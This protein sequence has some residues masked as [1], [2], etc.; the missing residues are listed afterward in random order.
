MPKLPSTTT[1]TAA[2]IAFSAALTNSLPV[3]ADLAAA[4]LPSSRSTQV[5]NMVTV[6]ST[7]I[8]TGSETATACRIE[9]QS[10]L[11][12]V[13]E[14]QTTDPATNLPTGVANT[15]VD[16]GPGQSQ[17]FVLSLTPTAIIDSVQVPFSFSCTS[18]A[19]AGTISGVNT[20]LLSASETP[21]VD[22]I[23]LAA[24]GG[25]TG[26]LSHD[27]SAGAFSLATVNVGA[28]DT[29][30]VTADTGAA[31]L[32]L[33]LSVCETNPD[34]GACVQGPAGS[35]D[36]TMST[37]ATPTFSV[38]SQASAAV[39]NNPAINRIFVRFTDSAAVV[40]GATSVALANELTNVPKFSQ[41]TLDVLRRVF[42]LTFSST[43]SSSS[44]SG[45]S[46]AGPALQV[47]TTIN[48]TVTCE[49]TGQLVV[50]GTSDVDQ[51]G[52]SSS[53]TI[54]FQNCDGINGEVNV[55][56]SVSLDGTTLSFETIQNGSYSAEECEEITMTDVQ[57]RGEVDLTDA[58]E[59]II[60]GNSFTTSGTISGRCEGET[61]SCSLDGVDLEDEDAFIDNCSG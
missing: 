11:P 21:V 46:A 12:I 1:A 29:V 48:E 7:V 45:I 24:T 55:T 5:D 3:S 52:G 51:N 30:T 17:S 27:D 37:G 14:Y 13:L 58:F 36:V 25:N 8:N 47:A 32:P 6:F 15:P 56:S 31:S 4:V 61:F 28:A 60:A 16:L 39:A 53:M 54:D 2:L 33:T 50:T 40:R 26:T 38:F 35:V 23:A 49:T 19:A 34:T 41:S 20:L 59:D 57:I 42:A 43:Q 9:H 44:S 18:G 22:V 10:G